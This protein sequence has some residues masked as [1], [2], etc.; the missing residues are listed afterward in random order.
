MGHIGQ[1]EDIAHGLLFLASEE[2]SFMTGSEKGREPREGER[3]PALG[4]NIDA[5]V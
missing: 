1:R 4:Y 3:G 2:P 5:D